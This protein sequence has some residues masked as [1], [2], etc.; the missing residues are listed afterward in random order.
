MLQLG[1]KKICIDVLEYQYRALLLCR[2]H[3]VFKVLGTGIP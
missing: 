3:A 2:Q 1:R